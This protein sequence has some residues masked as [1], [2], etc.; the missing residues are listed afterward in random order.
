MSDIFVTIK[1][2]HNYMIVLYLVK[3]KRM[4]TMKNSNNSSPTHL[5]VLQQLLKSF[6]AAQTLQCNHVHQISMRILGAIKRSDCSQKRKLR[7]GKRR[8]LG[9][10]TW[11]PAPIGASLLSVFSIPFCQFVLILKYF[12]L[13]FT[14]G[15]KKRLKS[16]ILYHY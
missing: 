13:L 6:N 5:S 9:M 11:P 12:F 15:F 4:N 1:H 16:K 8:E 2:K 14:P 10:T 3:V 7:R